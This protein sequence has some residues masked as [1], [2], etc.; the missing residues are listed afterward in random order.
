M[1][2]VDTQYF[3][4]TKAE[5][6]TMMQIVEMHS[7]HFPFTRY[8]DR[9]RRRVIMVPDDFGNLVPVSNSQTAHSLLS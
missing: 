1:P 9:A 3:T 5:R 2:G 7:F 6:P 4:N 8:S